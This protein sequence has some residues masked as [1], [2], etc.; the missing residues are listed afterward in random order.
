MSLCADLL[1]FEFDNLAN[2]DFSSKQS[3]YL[4][5]ITNKP[6]Q[7]CFANTSMLPRAFAVTITLEHSEGI[8]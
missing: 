6:H 1:F 3:D 4:I 2:I 8:F 5:A 7:K